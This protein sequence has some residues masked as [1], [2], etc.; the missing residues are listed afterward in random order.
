MM[1][2]YAS[3]AEWKKDQTVGNQGRIGLLQRLLKKTAPQ[4]TTTVKW[5]QGCWLSGETSKIYIHAETDHVQLGFHRGSSLK[6]PKKLLAGKGKYVRFIRVHSAK[7]IDAAAF[8]ALIL[9][10]VK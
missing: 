1:K 2:A 5:G 8:A 7:D 6:D 4:L 10:A 3:F 9:Q